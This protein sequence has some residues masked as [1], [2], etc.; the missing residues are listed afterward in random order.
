MVNDEWR[1]F[2]IHHSPFTIHHSPFTIR[3]SPLKNMEEK[4]LFDMFREESENLVE[5]PQAET[6]QRLEKRLATS[7]KRRQK[8]KPVSTQW[9]VVAATV[10]LIAVIGAASWIVTREHE[11]VLRG[12]KQFARLK[13]LAGHWS[14]SEGKIGD[15]LV[16]EEKTPFILRGVKTVTYKDAF[17]DSDS[18]LIEN[19]G[20]NT[21]F[22]HKNQ[23]YM[24][25]SIENQTFTF[26]ASKDGTT[27]RLRQ[28]AV[29]RFTL[30]FDKG[31]IFVYKS[32]ND[33]TLK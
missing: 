11:A 14:A 21:F 6:W 9:L 16:F 23:K 30:S 29:N 8:R 10:V 26:V 7:K 22:V 27:V 19:K 20:K 25:Q 2:T 24:L 3:H 28:S 5:Q 13:F 4:D 1:I 33:K 32:K 12:Q 17:I 15:E 18:F 31:K